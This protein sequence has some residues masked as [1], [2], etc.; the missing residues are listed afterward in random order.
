MD[1]LTVTRARFRSGSF[2]AFDDDGLVSREA[3]RTSDRQPYDSG[4]DDDGFDVGAQGRDAP[5]W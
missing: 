1:D 5:W 3:E 4:P 2:E